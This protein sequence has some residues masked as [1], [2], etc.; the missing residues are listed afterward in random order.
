MIQIQRSLFFLSF[1]IPVIW[2]FSLFIEIISFRGIEITEY[3]QF[4]TL[5]FLLPMLSYGASTSL[6]GFLLSMRKKGDPLLRAKQI[7]KENLDFPAY[8]AIHVA[9]VMPVYEENE[10]S[11]FS[12]IKVIFESVEKIYK[13]PKL[14]FFI[15]SDTRTPEKWIK[16]EAAY[17]EL[18][19]SK[20]NFHNFHYRR[21]KS[22][23]NGKSGNLADF[24]RRWGK[25]YKYMIVLDADSLV[26]GELIIQLIANMEKNPNAGIIQSSTKIFRSTTLFQKLTEFSSYLFSPFFLKGASFWQINAS[27]YW[28][29]NAILRVKPFM[30]HC[31]L[32]HLPEYGGLGGKILSHDTVEAALMRKAGF[33]V[34]CAYELKGSYEENP[35]N[36][37]DALKRDQRWCQGNLQHFWFLFGKKIPFINRIH[38][39]NGILSYLNSP[40]WMCYIILSLWNYLEDNK[41][42]NY[43]MLPEEYEFFK[44]QIYDPLYIKLLYLSL[45]L[46]F[47][48]RV[49]SFISLPGLQILKKF[50]AFLLETAISILVAPIYMIYHSI[51]V[52]S[53]LLNKRITWGPQN[54][55]ADLGYNIP[56]ILSS[57]FGVTILGFA[58]AYI[59]YTHSIMLFVLTMPIWIGWILSI[60]LVIL[61]GKE[62]KSLNKILDPSFWKPNTNLIGRLEEEL[63]SHKNSYLEGREFFFALVH[64]IF[65]NRH[66]QLQGNKLYQSKLPKSIEEDFEILLKQGPESLEKKSLLKILSNRELLDSFYWKFWTSRKTDW[67][68]YWL[69]IWEE[70]NP[71]FFPSISNNKKT[72]SNLQ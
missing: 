47:L 63:T 15:L 7:P 10:I 35:P 37:I 26:S 70:I 61:T 41:Y 64:P 2:G 8:E 22:N 6:F 51:F 62:Q 12:R 30:E 36:I 34:L 39:L 17:I 58:C 19:E 20:N 27:G 48:P 16:E 44:S 59:S 68:K 71:S 65:H 4:I 38:I 24:C 50:P 52:F 55:D 45:L 56:Y 60:P 69:T 67:A 42:L 72:D 14:D 25:K 66:K 18:C 46:L 43:S 54:R 33:E 57:F 28:G 11:I 40:I 21:R 31:A 3:Y 5:I 49:L 23:L 53:I 32:P 9:V 13:L 29:H 1:I